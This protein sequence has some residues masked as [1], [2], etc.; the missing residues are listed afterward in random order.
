M[1]RMRSSTWRWSRAVPS[2]PAPV[3]SPLVFG[4]P[5][6]RRW[7]LRAGSG[8]GMRQG[9]IAATQGRSFEA[10]GKCNEEMKEIMHRSV[11]MLS[12]TRQYRPRL[13]ETSPSGLTDTIEA[14]PPR[15]HRLIAPLIL[16]ASGAS[17]VTS[18][19]QPQRSLLTMA[20]LASP[21]TAFSAIQ[22]DPSALTWLPCR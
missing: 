6:W 10:T 18:P 20:A 1:L 3:G 21:R 16:A 7:P 15:G 4:A 19:S 13:D 8:P 14:S 12:A 9:R 11:R 17:L 22:M 5:R 2:Y